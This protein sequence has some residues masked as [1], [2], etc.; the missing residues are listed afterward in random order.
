MKSIEKEKNLNMC[1][2]IYPHKV[3]CMPNITLA[4]PEELHSRMKSHT[5]IRWSEVVRKSISEK[6][7]ELDIVEKIVG[8]SRLTEKDAAVI[9]KKIDRGVAQKLG[10]K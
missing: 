5:E 8:K 6:I 2:H 4:I 7:E 10:L 9:A 1:N 3:C